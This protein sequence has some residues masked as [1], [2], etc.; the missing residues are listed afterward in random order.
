MFVKALE[1]LLTV[2]SQADA[3]ALTAFKNLFV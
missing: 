2:A 1:L 3:S